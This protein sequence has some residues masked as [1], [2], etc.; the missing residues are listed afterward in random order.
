M[1]SWF[2]LARRGAAYELGRRLWVWFL[3]FE[4]IRIVVRRVLP[5]ALIAA[6]LGMTVWAAIR[7]AGWWLPRLT[8]LAVVAL[9][10][11]ATVWLARRYRWELRAGLPRTAVAA[12]VVALAGVLGTAL[13]HLR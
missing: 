5:A 3:A 4:I 7:T 13:Y 11:T 2:G 10:L 1:S 8:A 6:A 12:L 9:T